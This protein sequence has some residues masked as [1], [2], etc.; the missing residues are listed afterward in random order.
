MTMV[1]CCILEVFEQEKTNNNLILHFTFYW[2][3]RKFEHIVTNKFYCGHS[4]DIIQ[5]QSS[6][7]NVFNVLFK[8]TKVQ[9]Y[10]LSFRCAPSPHR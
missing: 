10:P 3:E 5:H 4:E 6:L 1:F 7:I 2:D 8:E 9:S